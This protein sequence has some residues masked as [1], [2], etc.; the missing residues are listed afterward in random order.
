MM[1]RSVRSAIVGTLLFCCGT[2]KT[3]D[4]YQSP[5]TLSNLEGNEDLQRLV[6]GIESTVNPFVHEPVD[7]LYCITTGVKVADEMKEDLL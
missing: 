1:T 3:E 2:K 5:Q 4:I 6:A 7:N